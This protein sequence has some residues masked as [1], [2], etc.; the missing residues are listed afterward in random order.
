MIDGEQNPVQD[1]PVNTAMALQ[2]EPA[3]EILLMVE[4]VKSDIDCTWYTSPLFS[5][6][7]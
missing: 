7:V 5:G 1:D 3:V 4:P 2:V 6:T